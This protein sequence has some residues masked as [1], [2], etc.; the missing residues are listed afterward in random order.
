MAPP[1]ET[2]GCPAKNTM[3]QK[4][5]VTGSS[6][7]IGA[8][9]ARRLFSD[10]WNVLIHYNQSFTAAAALAKELNTTAIQA[11][12]EDPEQVQSLFDQAGPVRLLVCSAGIAQYGLFSEI[13]E[14]S[15]HQLLEVNLS[16]VYRCCRA[17]I[18]GMVRQKEGN[19]I[20]ISSVWGLYGASCEAGYAAT[21]AG[22]IGLTKSLAKELGPSG[23]RVNCV[24]PGVID[25]DMLSQFDRADRQALAE[26]TPLGRIGMPEE[27][28]ELVAFLA[29]DRAAFITGQTIGVDGGFGM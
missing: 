27:V 15:W 26:Q 23:I 28:A 3:N 9:V 7:G 8:A 4:A 2:K 19:I 18:P 29:S 6:R 17:A 24:A 25:T 16:G 11:D 13:D 14:T 10:G 1:S 12:M 20:L 22:I 21:K 5:L